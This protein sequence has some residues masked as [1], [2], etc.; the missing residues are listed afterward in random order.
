MEWIFKFRYFPREILTIIFQSEM[1][2]GGIFLLNKNI[3]NFHFANFWYLSYI[4]CSV[5]LKVNP[6]II[7]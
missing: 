1:G 2:I 3:I 5:A 7:K 6:P 4:T